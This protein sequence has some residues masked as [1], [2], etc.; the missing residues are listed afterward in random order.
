MDLEEDQDE[1]YEHDD[2]EE[3]YD[4][5]TFMPEN[6]QGTRKNKEVKK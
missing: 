4:K 3:I 2:D 5:G 6:K 1:M